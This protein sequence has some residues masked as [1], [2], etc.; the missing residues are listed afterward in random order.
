[1]KNVHHNFPESKW[2]PKISFFVQLAV[3]KKDSSLTVK[4][5]KEKQ[6]ILRSWNQQMFNLFIGGI[7]EISD[8]WNNLAF[9]CSTKL[10]QLLICFNKNKLVLHTRAA[11]INHLMSALSDNKLLCNYFDNILIWLI[12]SSH[13]FK[14]K[15]KNSLISA[16][17]SGFCS[18]LWQYSEHICAGNKT[19]HLRTSFWTLGNTDQQFLTV[20]RP[21]KESINREQNWQTIWRGK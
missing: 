1:M 19:G 7:I 20:Y 14:K 12:F 4:D 8:N 2:R 18:P 17:F 11:T 21:N 3:L 15:I 16:L 9:D 10:L 6:Q 13:L 5:D